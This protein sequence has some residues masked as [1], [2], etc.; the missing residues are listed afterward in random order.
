MMVLEE[1]P[2][3]GVTV[4]L[5]GADMRIKRAWLIWSQTG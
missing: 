3:P 1:K 2:K 5:N 4:D